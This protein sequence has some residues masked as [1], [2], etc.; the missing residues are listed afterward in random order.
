VFDYGYES[1]EA[2]RVRIQFEEIQAEYRANH[3]RTLSEDEERGKQ[4]EEVLA[5]HKELDE[6]SRRVVEAAR[7]GQATP[8]EPAS[9]WTAPREVNTVMSLGEFEDEDRASTWSAPTPPMG[10]PPPP[11][12]PDPVPDVEQ[13]RSP[14]TQPVMS[15]GEFEDD[16]QP[17]GRSSQPPPRPGRRRLRSDDD[18]DLSGQS[19]MS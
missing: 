1:P 10:F 16:E 9:P 14:P 3:D 6:E 5:K 4:L 8:D 2:Q 12:I 11:P 19:W 15:L 7:A 17:A 13:F 18:E